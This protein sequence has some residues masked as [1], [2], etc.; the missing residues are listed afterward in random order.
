MTNL[1]AFYE[2][3]GDGI[4]YKDVPDDIIQKYSTTIPEFLLEIWKTKGLSFFKDG[5][6][7][8]VNPDEYAEILSFFIPKNE[9]L[10]VVIRTAFGGLI[11]LDDNSTKITNKGEPYNYLC[12]INKEITGFTDTL[13][14]VMNGWLTTEEIYAPLMFSNFYAWARERLPIPAPDE[15]YGFVPAIALGG[16]LD[17]EN[18]Q[19]VKIKEHMAIL[20]QL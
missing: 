12:P 13:D 9:N 10:H 15:C 2:F 20:S 3:N 19:I 5:F 4:F 11:F 8:L 17:P 18:I 6:F 16:D 7:W 14:A 1:R